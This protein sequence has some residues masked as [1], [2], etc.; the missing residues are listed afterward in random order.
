M[1]GH[2]YSK[3]RRISNLSITSLRLN[4]PLTLYIDQYHTAMGISPTDA[5]AAVLQGELDKHSP[6][7]TYSVTQQ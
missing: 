7:V 4:I 5:N 2:D 1:H 6:S 3:L